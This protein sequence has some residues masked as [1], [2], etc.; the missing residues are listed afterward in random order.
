MNIMKKIFLPALVVFVALA[1]YAQKPTLRPLQQSGA[2]VL[3]T[4]V[5]ANSHYIGENYGGGIVFYVYDNGL[6]GLIA[7]TVDQSSGIEWWGGGPFT[8]T[9]AKADGVGAGLKNTAIIIANQGPV[10]GMMF[11][12]RVCNEYTVTAGGVFYGDW[13]LPSKFEL[14]LLYLQKTL[15][16]GFTNNIYWA[17][18][19]INAQQA[20]FQ[21]FTDGA[22]AVGSTVKAMGFYVRAIRAF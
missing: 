16:G 9:C 13:Y 22:Q 20:C 7:A 2:T 3:P 18:T 1:S 4:L 17:S 5:Y 10:S 11:A 19:E 21:N 14:N 6:H 15:A 12:A 8:N